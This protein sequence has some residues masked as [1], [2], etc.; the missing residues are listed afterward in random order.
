MTSCVYSGRYTGSYTIQAKQKEENIKEISIDFI[1]QLADKNS[2]IKDKKFNG[3]DTLGFLGKPYHYFKFW[4]EQ[5]DSSTIVK[6]DYWGISG[7]RK[8]QPYKNLFNEL[9]DFM[10]K[11]FII[12]EQNIKGQNNL[13]TK[14]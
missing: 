12:V 4:F 8:T 7:S 5:G 14:K 2:L 11:K 10:Q 9:N 6:L 3:I 13:K 1:N